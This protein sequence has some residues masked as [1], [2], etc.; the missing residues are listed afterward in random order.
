M[1]NNIEQEKL[2]QLIKT[3][4]KDGFCKFNKYNFKD[5]DV[6][7]K[8][9]ILKLICGVVNEEKE[10]FKI[11]DI[12]SI[13]PINC[14]IQQRILSFLNNM[15]TYS[16]EQMITRF[17]S[18]SSFFYELKKEQKF[19]DYLKEKKVRLIPF[20]TMLGFCAYVNLGK[21]IS[22]NIIGLMK[23]KYIKNIID[24]Y[25]DG[26]RKSLSHIILYY[27][28]MINT[29]DEGKNGDSK[30]NFDLLYNEL[31]DSLERYICFNEL[32]DEG[33][34]VH[35]VNCLYKTI[36]KDVKLIYLK[37]GPEI[38]IINNVIR[39]IFEQIL[40]N[41]SFKNYYQKSNINSLYDYIADI[42]KNLSEE[43]FE[44]NYSKFII[45]YCKKYKQGNKNI[46]ISFLSGLNPDNFKEIF[47]NLN[48]NGNDDYYNNIGFYLSQI[49]AK[50]KKT[51]KKDSSI[52]INDSKVNQEKD[53]FN[54]IK[55]LNDLNNDSFQTNNNNEILNEESVDIM[56][57]N[58]LHNVNTKEQSKNDQ[59][60]KEFEEMK[61]QMKILKEIIN[62]ISQ[63]N[64]D[65]KE[66]NKHIKEENNH[67]I[68]EN[69]HIIEENKHIKE[70]FRKFKDK[71]I[72]THIEI[73]SELFKL[74]K[75]MK[76]ISY[77]DISKPIINNYI[78]KYQNK[79]I[80][81]KNLKNKKDK[82]LFITKYLTGQESAYYSKIINKYY[83]SNEMSHISKIFND[84]GKN[85]IIG[86]TLEKNDIIDKI[87]N[88][89]CNIILDEKVTNNNNM[90]ID[91]LFGVKKIIKELAEN[92]M[93][94]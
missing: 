24:K 39:Y 1:E 35:F 91:K 60:I 86:L 4:F 29:Y 20:F 37:K 21:D 83:D 80:K 26:T 23:K 44:E 52:Q 59:M 89:Y 78:D 70:D 66:D 42:I 15:L 17:D 34:I 13:I 9:E 61:N 28:K 46:V 54:T 71:S 47:N 7:Y 84:F 87:F 57:N 45:N 94:D 5:E 88:D 43:T 36:T 6:K 2:N 74:K 73:K 30:Q 67:I 31:K 92:Q 82:A 65:I 3:L 64:K 14:L 76:A 72:N 51:N 53:S 27:N 18:I 12:I 50:K 85:Y 8:Y 56:N 19:I 81:E 77:R 55:D 16:I 25:I 68:E 93:I 32:Y 58:E 40:E 38:T 48:I 69:K 62:K 11:Q 41:F 33:E 49:S 10:D 63:E 90:L 75:E 22:G 79:L